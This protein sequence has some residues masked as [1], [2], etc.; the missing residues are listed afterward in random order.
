MSDGLSV[1]FYIHFFDIMDEEIVEAIEETRVSGIIPENLNTT[2]LTRIPKV[3]RPSN[4][5]EYRPIALCNLLY[6]LITKI[7]WTG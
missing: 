5:G 6:K 7:I 4:F 2:Y 1:E 3:D